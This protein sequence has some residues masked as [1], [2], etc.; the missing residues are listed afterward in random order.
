MTPVQ[1]VGLIALGVVYLAGCATPFIVR[2]AWKAWSG[3]VIVPTSI[4]KTP[5]VHDEEEDEEDAE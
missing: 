2:A 3:I 5:F 4:E 1:W